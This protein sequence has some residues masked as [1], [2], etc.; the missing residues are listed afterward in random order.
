M[1]IFKLTNPHFYITIAIAVLNGALLC[2]VAGK[3][4]QI[5]QLSGYKLKGYNAWLKDTKIKFVGR[6][7]MLSFLSLISV[8]V[9]NSLLSGFD[10][11]TLYLGFI[12]Y[13]Y[14]C[15]VF[16]IN[17][18]KMPQKTPLKQTRRMNRLIGTTFMLCAM[19]SFGLIAICTEFIPFIRYGIIVIT[20]MC[21]TFIVP[22]AHLITVPFENLIR[23]KYIKSA[24]AKLSKMPNLIKIGIT[25][26]FG[27]TTTK[28][29]LNVILSK[30]YSVCMTPH[31]FNTPMGLTKV[32]LKYLKMNNQVLIAEMGA[33][34]VGDIKYLC[35]LINPKH[36]IITSVG[37]QH[38]ATFGTEENI[39]K[40][41]NELVQAIT[42]GYV[43]FNA[44]NEGAVK[45]YDAC[46]AEKYL[47][48]VENDNAFC[49]IKNVKIGADGSQF[50]LC[51]DG[52]CV[53]CSTKLLGKHNLQD[54]AMAS[55]MAFKAGV[56]LDKI[57]QAIGE[58]KPMSHRLEVIKNNR[59]IIIDNSY[60]S[61]VE[62][63]ASALEVLGLFDGG[64]KIIITPG[65]VEMGD[66]EFETNVNFGK[67]IAKTCNKVII[68]N[69]V[70]K[71]A[72][73]QGLQEQGFDE[74]NVYTAEDLK[75]ATAMLS[76]ITEVGD[77]VLF[78]N[79]LP[80]NYT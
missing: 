45:L 60:N 47:A 2:F 7:F 36:A 65:I 16:I 26:S 13:I 20:P 33:R 23:K 61:S 44:Q 52:K 38:L 64:N 39:A 4:F 73:K 43:V 3:L 66:K 56:E 17:M 63:S 76:D 75:T 18:T 12:F 41:K 24:K 5:L 58:L 79:D 37:S 34:N 46:T 68:V 11:Y 29:I 10:G 57:A 40:T 59:F 51:I 25:G 54:I 15:I 55:A 48:G 31:S 9:T 14:F 1:E 27:K 42:D 74:N 72:I 22:L 6:L 35:D 28:H 8:L 78:E 21:L 53:P 77:V 32:V 69:Q 71:D 62:S 80:D 50:D 30:K 49:N 70:N 67:A 19:L